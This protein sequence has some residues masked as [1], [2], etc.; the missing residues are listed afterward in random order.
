M[1]FTGISCRR[2]TST[3]FGVIV[4]IGIIFSAVIPMLLVMRQA[5]TFHDISKHELVISDQERM[6]EEIYVYVFPVT[7]DSTTLTLEV[8]NR[9]NLVVN[10]VQVWINDVPHQFDDFGVQPM[11]WL[12]RDLDY[13]TAV[14]D[15]WYFIKIITDRG[16]IFSSDSGSLYYDSGGN[17][18]EGMFAINFLIS[19]PAAGWF[20]IEIRQGDEYGPILDGTPFQIHKSSSGSAFD[21][22]NVPSAITYHVKITK[23]LELIYEDDVTIDWPN[24]SPIEWVF[25]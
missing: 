21:F 24:G 18:T 8:Q 23:N 1:L 9:G 11:S 15:N 20:D 2:G 10:V 13:F 12:G 4:F 17:W 16:N 6:D 22:F 3:I 5:D 14:P 7:E 19:Y 25:A